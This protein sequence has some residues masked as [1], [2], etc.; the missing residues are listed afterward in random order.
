MKNLTKLFVA[1]VALFALSCATDMT[2]DLGI[3]GNQ[4]TI[5]L[6]LEETRTQLGEKAGELY[7]VLWSEGDQISVNGVASEPLT[8]SQAGKSSAVF[9]VNGVHTTFNIAYPATAEGQVLFAS[10]QTHAGNTTF[11]KGVATLY[12]VG[13]ESESVALN[14]LT[15]VLKI[16]VTGSA[17]LTHAQ[18]STIDRAPI[19]GAFD[20]DFASGEVT[21]SAGATSVINYSFGEGVELSSV[22]TFLHIAVPA[23]EYN[24]LYVTLY[25]KAGGVMYATI[26]TS[27]QKPL[28]AGKVREFSNSIAYQATETLHIVKDAESLKALAT[29]TSDAILV[30]DIDLSEVDW[31]PIEGYASHT[32]NG[33]GYAIKGLK[34]PL[35][36]TT[37]ASIRGLHLT[38]VNISVTVDPNVGALAINHTASDT[39][40]PVLE[41]CS[42][43]GKITVNCPDFA[44][45]STGYTIGGLVAHSYGV[46]VANCVNR[47]NI[48][49]QQPVKQNSN[50]TVSY[51]GK[52]GG[53][54]GHME[55]WNGATT[56]AT[57][58]IN[59]CVNYGKLSCK[60][61]S[62]SGTVTAGTNPKQSLVIGGIIGVCATTN[63]EK[64]HNLVNRGDIDIYET[65]NYV[66]GG[67]CIG[68]FYPN[69]ASLQGYKNYGTITKKSGYAQRYVIGGIVGVQQ[70]NTTTMS[71]C[72]NH[73]NLV[74]EEG[75]TLRQVEVG[76]VAGILKCSI[77]NC[78]NNAKILFNGDIYTRTSAYVAT[79]PFNIGGIAGY[80]V[81]SSVI[82]NCQNNVSGVIE[83][84]GS[85]VD[86]YTNL[87]DVAIGGVGGYSNGQF[88]NCTNGAPIKL[89]STI[90]GVA[91]SDKYIVS[92]G[93]CV[94]FIQ[95]GKGVTNCENL[96][97]ATMTIEPTLNASSMHTI[98]IGGVVGYS[99]ETPVSN[100]TNRAAIN[101]GGQN[102]MRYQIAGC[103]A[104]VSHKENN[105]SYTTNLHNY[106]S[107]TAKAYMSAE[108]SSDI[109]ATNV[110]GIACTISGASSH[111]Y[112]HKGADIT[113]QHTKAHSNMNVSG[114]VC[115]N[116]YDIDT[117]T[118]EGNIYVAGPCGGE[119]Y[120]SCF[121]AG[122]FAN[123][124]AVSTKKNLTNKGNITVE[125]LE[126]TLAINIGGITSAAERCALENCHNSGNITVNQNKA[127][128]L[129]GIMAVGGVAS[130][131]A[132][133]AQLVTMSNCTN[134]GAVTVNASAVTFPVFVGGVYA[135]HYNHSSAVPVVVIADENG[136]GVA[137]S[138]AVS[139]I[140]NSETEGILASVG[141]VFGY[142]N[143]PLVS[144][145][146]VWT[147]SVINSG[148]V[149]LTS[150]ASPA[151]IGG[152]FG[153]TLNA[154]SDKA[155]YTNSG[156]ITCTGNMNTA[157]VGGFV[158]ASD[159]TVT[160]GTVLCS[161]TAV[162]SKQAGM[163]MGLPYSE[164]T[165][166][167]NCKV[168]GKICNSIEYNEEADDDI[169][170]EVEL[171][172]ANYMRHLYSNAISADQATAD[173]CSYI[174]AIK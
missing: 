130:G 131:A 70:H 68:E 129:K 29:A 93:G 26:N 96:A 174:S 173:G 170:I 1:V 118:N 38:D 13:S 51:T 62:H 115:D 125:N 43:S 159:S 111:L 110:A 103:V 65:G 151:Y 81:S 83:L 33:N 55:A 149:S 119:S 127:N 48:D 91:S 82:D 73:G 14:H 133:A 7:P 30:N 11:G 163:I 148:A 19:A 71:D 60:D 6:S 140:A 98:F 45:V 61:A 108:G 156:N 162:G 3:G 52:I 158:G 78:S 40:A 106:G 35:F 134:T 88:T 169:P 76:G 89:T 80:I 28:T 124:S 144:G 54:I 168:G 123:Y 112:N 20:I 128:M 135:K 66:F 58:S 5:E 143:L 99:Y 85:I 97:T 167:T 116:E 102:R 92:L 152:I 16:G 74:V 67:G 160:N 59:D 90:S 150:G 23:G 50:T 25:D 107:I 155:T 72:H 104:I 154:L 34:A 101:V 32:L 36:G 9:T 146:S 79:K 136:V 77:N 84:N 4:T 147:G 126:N 171:S 12:G 120:G 94:G 109:G 165:K 24:E 42:A 86:S 100:L 113:V 64:C 161:L 138:G 39:F 44:A 137:N 8:A 145:E 21:P 164:A 17:T 114:I 49:I 75:V 122:V 18:I 27:E 46:A 141:G 142:S 41:N 166:A 117:A 172:S 105:T 53:I 57:A 157:Y 87:A 56:P 37:G 10:E 139:L 95:S 121:I 15:G 63:A 69:T 153:Y 2:E 132:A 47:V 22:K 31:T